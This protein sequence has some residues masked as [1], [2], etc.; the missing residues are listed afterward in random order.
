[1]G[2]QAVDLSS[3][4]MYSMG[5]ILLEAAWGEEL[6]M[7]SQVMR[8]EWDGVGIQVAGVSEALG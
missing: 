3:F 2:A 6:E 7:R 4:V 1:L 5:S 8:S